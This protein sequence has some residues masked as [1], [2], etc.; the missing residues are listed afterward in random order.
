M[1]KYIYIF[2]LVLSIPFASLNSATKYLMDPMPANERAPEFTL[3]GM[4]EKTHT[5]KSLREKNFWVYG[6][7]AKGEKNFTEVKWEGN[8][9]ELGKVYSNPYATAFKPQETIKE[10]DDSNKLVKVFLA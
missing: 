5:L 2:L 10:E 6:F 9:V 4:D 1:K 7:D 8:P 3:M